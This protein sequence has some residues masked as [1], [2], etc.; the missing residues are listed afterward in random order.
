M[1]QYIAPGGASDQLKEGEIEGT[2]E[3]SDGEDWQESTE[4]GD[5]VVEDSRDM[6]RN[7]SAA[8]LST[9]TTSSRNNVSKQSGKSPLPPPPFNLINLMQ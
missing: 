1:E 3:D 2:E 8:D 9:M 7:L 6:T 4:D 5:K